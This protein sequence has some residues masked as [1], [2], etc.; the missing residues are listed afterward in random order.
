MSSASDTHHQSG[1][2]RKAKPSAKLPRKMTQTSALRPAP[3]KPT[4]TRQ[5]TVAIVED[6]ALV[7]ASLAQLINDAPGYSCACLCSTAEE[8]LKQIPFVVPDV[9]LM[10]IQLPGA[11]GIECTRKLKQ[12]LPGLQILMLTV[13]EDNERIFNAL[14]AGASGYLLKRAEPEEILQAV[15]EVKTGGAP[16]SSQIARRVV[17]SF[18]K[19]LPGS[20]ADVA[21][22]AREQEIL[23]LLT[24]GYSNKEIAVQIHISV[25]TVCTHLQ[26]IYQKLHVRGRTEAVAK[27]LQ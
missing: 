8:A 25:P 4:P 21:L 1:G 5:A 2:Y 6:D 7:R 23:S 24:K 12:A 15:G 16:M 26:H 13:Y 11:S 20:D 27:A 10:D 14:Q 9:A 17:E 19:P 18:R 3:S 22:S